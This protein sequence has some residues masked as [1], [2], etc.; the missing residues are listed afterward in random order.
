VFKNVQWIIALGLM[1]LLLLLSGCGLGTRGVVTLDGTE[2]GSTAT[3]APSVDPEDAVFAFTDCMREHGIDVPDPQTVGGGGGG[4]RVFTADPSNR[5]DIDP[6]SDEFQAAME[7]CRQY[8]QGFAGDDGQGPDLTVEQEQALL[9]F[10]ECMREQGIDM[11]DPGT[12]G[13]FVGPGPDASEGERPIDPQS[14]EFQA[15]MEAC[16]DNLEGLPGGGPVIR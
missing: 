3:P 16:R 2:D 14:D 7:A 11:P 9:D 6:Q 12:G 5:P 10:T 15:A 13:F 1:L 4:G 8:L